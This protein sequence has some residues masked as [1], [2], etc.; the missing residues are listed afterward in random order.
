MDHMFCETC[1]INRDHKIAEILLQFNH[2]ELLHL[3][4]RQFQIPQKLQYETSHHVYKIKLQNR[5]GLFQ[6]S[7]LNR[8]HVRHRNRK[9]HEVKKKMMNMTS[10]QGNSFGQKFCF[11]VLCLVQNENVQIARMNI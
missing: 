7:T 5:T 6:V 4:F 8:H 10:N 11:K 3:N 2:L 1:Q 9:D